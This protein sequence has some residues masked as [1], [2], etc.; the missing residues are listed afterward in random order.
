MQPENL[1]RVSFELFLIGIKKSCLLRAFL[2]VREEHDGGISGIHLRKL[3]RSRLSNAKGNIAVRA[4][5]F[6]PWR[7]EP[8]QTIAISAEARTTSVSTSTTKTTFATGQ[9]R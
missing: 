9:S 4:S 1:I 3:L 2:H 8:C 5:F 7:N 6:L